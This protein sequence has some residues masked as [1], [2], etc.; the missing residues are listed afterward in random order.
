M[1]PDYEKLYFD[2]VER[3]RQTEGQL[4]Q[5]R[6]KAEQTKTTFEEFLRHCHSFLSE[7]LK[8]RADAHGHTTRATSPPRRVCPTY[9]RPWVDFQTLQSQ[10]FD[11]VHGLL[12]PSDRPPLRYFT[13]RSDLEAYGR[14]LWD[15]WLA[16]ERDLQSSD[17]FAVEGQ[18]R[19]LITMLRSIPATTTLFPSGNDI[20][21]EY[22]AN[23]LDSE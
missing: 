10:V 2:V 13:P 3:R 11:H 8:V 7:P 17:R 9:L 19:A 14:L 21:F 12:H 18:V 1:A 16:S 20:R 4:H 5:E 6:E 23:A 15:R 22:H